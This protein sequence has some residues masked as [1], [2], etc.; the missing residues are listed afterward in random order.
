MVKDLNKELQDGIFEKIYQF[1]KVFQPHTQDSPI[2]DLCEDKYDGNLIHAPEYQRRFVWS[3]VHSKQTFFDIQE[4]ELGFRH[5]Y[6]HTNQ[7]LGN[8]VY[9]A[10][11]PFETDISSQIYHLEVPYLS[12]LPS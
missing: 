3:E 6:P 1:Q 5:I 8:L 12:P 7:L 9:E 4:H 11:I 2:I 10:E